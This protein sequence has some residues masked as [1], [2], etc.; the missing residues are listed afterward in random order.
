MKKLWLREI[1][2]SLEVQNANVT[3]SL[4][5]VVKFLFPTRNMDYE[6]LTLFRYGIL[7][8]KEYNFFLFTKICKPNTELSTEVF[9][10]IHLQTNDDNSKA[11]ANSMLETYFS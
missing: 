3:F 9:T 2:I 8:S 1:N 5:Q 11:T 4:F 6:H 7:V 10:I